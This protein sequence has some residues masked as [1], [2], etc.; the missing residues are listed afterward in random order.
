VY[1]SRALFVTDLHAR[2]PFGIPREELVPFPE[3]SAARYCVATNLSGAIGGIGLAKPWSES[4]RAEG[5]CGDPG[6]TSIPR[7]AIFG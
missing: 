7:R 2:G 4:N 5:L 1:E 3:A 6:G